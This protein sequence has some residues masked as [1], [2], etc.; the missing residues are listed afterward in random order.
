MLHTLHE[1]TEIVLRK[2]A[3]ATLTHYDTQCSRELQN[4]QHSILLMTRNRT[5]LLTSNRIACK[6]N[7][8]FHNLHNEV[9][10]KLCQEKLGVSDRGLLRAAKAHHS[11]APYTIAFLCKT[12]DIVPVVFP[13]CAK[14]MDK[15][16]R[17]T[18]VSKR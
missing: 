6:S 17:R 2:F 8:L 18:F 16:H 4:D 11:Q 1:D 7:G 3:I 15:H 10:H 5:I 12:S 13:K 9:S 14:S